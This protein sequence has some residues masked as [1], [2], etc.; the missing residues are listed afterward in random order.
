M[1]EQLINHTLSYEIELKD[2][3][4][5]HLTYNYLKTIW[6]ISFNPR[7]LIHIVLSLGNEQTVQDV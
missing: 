2:R 1:S 6:G 3:I 7:G 5:L 4:G